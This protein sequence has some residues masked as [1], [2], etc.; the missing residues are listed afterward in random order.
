MQMFDA[1]SMI[2]AWDNY[3]IEQFPGLWN[4]MADRVARGLI[5]MSEVAVEEVG[6]KAP[7]CAAWLK[8]FDMRKLPVTEAIL[9]EAMRFKA[10]LEIEEDR[11]GSGVDEND[12]I[13]IATAKVN[14]CELVTNEAFQSSANKQKRNWKI[15]A[16]CNMD[17]VH[18]EWISYLDYLKRTGAI[19]G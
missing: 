17:T 16:V 10:L 14:S 11:Y 18:V 12:L 5:Q 15:P 3:P 6:H 9:L 1:S 2:Y 8:N 4:W 19:F 13:I 7:E